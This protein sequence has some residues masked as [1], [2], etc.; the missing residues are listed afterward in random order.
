MDF[1]FRILDFGLLL[2]AKYFPLISNLRFCGFIQRGLTQNPEAR[3][4]KID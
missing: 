1:G 4:S 3:K 2:K